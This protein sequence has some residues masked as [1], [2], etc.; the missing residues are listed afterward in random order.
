M[1]QEGGL[2]VVNESEVRSTFPA[3]MNLLPTSLPFPR[4]GAFSPVVNAS[5]A[6]AAA[7]AAG[8]L[9]AGDYV[10]SSESPSFIHKQMQFL[11]QAGH[12]QMLMSGLYP[13]APITD[14]QVIN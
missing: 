9:D 1:L 7:A 5:A 4:G 14:A 2:G 3:R 10:N 12:S 11:E 13:G 6:A 8:H